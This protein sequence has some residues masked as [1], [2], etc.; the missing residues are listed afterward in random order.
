MYVSDFHSLSLYLICH[1]LIHPWGRFCLSS[2]FFLFSNFCFAFLSKI[3]SCVHT[4]SRYFSFTSLEQWYSIFPLYPAIGGW[5]QQP[6][7]KHFTLQT[8]SM[9]L[10]RHFSFTGFHT[11]IDIQRGFSL[12]CVSNIKTL[13]WPFSAFE[14][15]NRKD[16]K[17]RGWFIYI[18]SV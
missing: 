11:H 8:E 3:F 12:I 9:V 10:E 17:N 7:D 15:F 5:K 14:Q 4:A 16:N 1:Y 2:V 18:H 13:Y 6:A